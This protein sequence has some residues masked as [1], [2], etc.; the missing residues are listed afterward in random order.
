M[1][2]AAE[3]HALAEEYRRRARQT[4]ITAL[5]VEFYARAHLYAGKAFRIDRDGWPMTQREINDLV[6]ISWA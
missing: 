4:S 1:T 2:R 3:L 5:A 6:E